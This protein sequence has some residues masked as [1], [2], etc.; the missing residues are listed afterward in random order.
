[1]TRGADI[2]RDAD[3]D[4]DG[5]DNSSITRRAVGRSRRGVLFCLVACDICIIIYNG[6]R[7]TLIGTAGRETER[8]M[9]NS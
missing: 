3:D 2:G 8:T 6:R 5:V 4:D 1:M 9:R 7:T